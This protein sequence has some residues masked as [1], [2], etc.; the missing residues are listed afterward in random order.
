MATKRDELQRLRSIASA[1]GAWSLHAQQ[2]WAFRIEVEGLADEAVLALT[3]RAVEIAA[4][5]TVQWRAVAVRRGDESLFA[6]TA[7]RAQLTAL[8]EVERSILH[9][10]QSDLPAH[11]E[12][13]Q[14]I[15]GNWRAVTFGRRRKKAESAARYL[16]EFHFWA[17]EVDLTELL[18]RLDDRHS[19]ALP[20]TLSEALVSKTGLINSLTYLGVPT[21]ITDENFASIPDATFTIAKALACLDGLPDEAKRA[22]AAVRNAETRRA[23]RAMPVE[24]LREATRERIRVQPLR[25]AGILTVANVLEQQSRLASLRGIGYQSA[26]AIVGAA[27]E[28]Q[29]SV[30]TEMPVRIDIKAVNDEATLL[31]VLLA[32]WQALRRARLGNSDAALA[33]KVHPLEEVIDSETVHLLLFEC[34]AK[35]AEFTTITK[36]L[37]ERARVMQSAMKLPD[38]PWSDFR[39]GAADYYVLLQELGLLV[40]DEQSVTGGLPQDVVTRVRSFELETKH[41]SVSLRGYQA[42]GAR[43][44]LVQKKVIIGDEMGLGKT[45]EALAVLAHLHAKG[46]RHALVVCPA[47]VVTN[48]MREVASKSDLQPRRLHGMGRDHE[49]RDWVRRGGVGVTTY[50]SLGWLKDSLP[51]SGELACM[52][53]DEAHYIKNP[54]A[55]RSVRTLNLIKKADHALLLTGTPLE[56]RVDEFR[57]LVGYVKPELVVDATD[58]RPKLFRK[59][60]AT[61]YLRRNQESVLT[62]L[63]ELIEVDEW[64]S[65]SRSDHAAYRT[66]VIDGNFA[67]M[68]QA[69]MLAAHG[70][71]KLERLVEIVE[72]AEANGRK[73]LVFSQFLKVLDVVAHAL[74]GRVVGPLTGSVPAAKRQ[75]MVDDFTAAAPGAVLVSQ[76]VAG[77]I[78]LNIQAASVVIICEPQ[79]KPTSEW[80]AIARARRM[81]QLES[82]QVHR[83]LSDEG[84]DVRI[85]ELLARK[86][87]IFAEFAA[88]SE[89]AEQAPEAF[90]ISEA[91][92]V[93]EV[94]QSERRRLLE[95]LPPAEVD[96]E[97]ESLAG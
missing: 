38:D 87:E 12:S 28:I 67:V 14:A 65:M 59:Q 64:V 36:T 39:A 31:L 85:S 75:V 46:Q 37:V 61:A 78:G 33:S 81:G 34:A 21:L 51:S 74:R 56:N 3:S 72:E 5:G 70:S 84:V 53:V 23:V 62:E 76:I 96:T 44:S 16:Q 11:V 86:R 71:A 26:R 40:E 7:R 43:F 30:Y 50:G 27:L 48:W 6:L 24:R 35:S 19:V 54:E 80:Q 68:R 8:S 60:V 95:G 97:D 83:L 2:I 18:K 22:G 69:A 93:K 91:E 90:D 77:G 79:L 55:L 47:A 66:A 58:L 45:I 32:G 9:R 25:D 29:N 88:R 13:A 20:P 73:V 49:L 41:L 63:P 57:A 52:I 92:L 4:D 1:I 94:L 82:V 17:G 15:L 42:F 89:L 10:L